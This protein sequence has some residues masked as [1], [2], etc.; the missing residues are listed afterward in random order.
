M[1]VEY[2]HIRRQI[3]VKI[4]RMVLGD[5]SDLESF[6]DQ[7]FI[8]DLKINLIIGLAENIRV[9]VY[10]YIEKEWDFINQ[11][12]R[13]ADDQMLENLSKIK[14][15]NDIIENGNS[16]EE[17]NNN[18][19]IEGE[20]VQIIDGE[21]SSANKT[22]II[23]GKTIT[24]LHPRG[25]PANG[26]QRY[27]HLFAAGVIDTGG[28][29]NP[30]H[31]VDV[32]ELPVSI[33]NKFNVF[34][35]KGYSLNAG[36]DLLN[37]QCMNHQFSI[38][39]L[40][41]YKAAT[42]GVNIPFEVFYSSVDKRYWPDP[43]DS[44]TI[45]E[46][47]ENIKR[48]VFT[49]YKDIYQAKNPRGADSALVA[50][51]VGELGY[52]RETRMIYIRA[53]D[54]FRRLYQVSSLTF[55]VNRNTITI[56]ENSMAKVFMIWLSSLK[57]KIISEGGW[58]NFS[59]NEYSVKRL[60][61]ILSPKRSGIYNG[62]D[63]N[64][65]ARALLY[66]ETNGLV[67]YSYEFLNKRTTDVNDKCLTLATKIK[68]ISHRLANKK[69][70]FDGEYLPSINIR[71][72]KNT[73]EK[74]SNIALMINSIQFLKG[75]NASDS[76]SHAEWFENNRKLLD[77]I[78][79]MIEEVYDKKGP[80]EAR[81]YLGELHKIKLNTLLRNLNQGNHPFSPKL[82]DIISQSLAKIKKNAIKP[83]TDLLMSI[84]IK[85]KPHKTNETHISWYDKNEKNIML[86]KKT[87]ESIIAKKGS[88]SGVNKRTYKA[89]LID[90]IYFYGDEELSLFFKNAYDNN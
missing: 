44:K 12:I 37:M 31:G 53:V 90:P 18:D 51:I 28:G 22:E 13:V 33:E 43:E 47:F 2:G 11:H 80:V 66:L 3:A 56:A 41:E 75:A 76:F 68:F 84:I 8:P 48:L 40:S 89:R 7:V 9:D 16:L 67:R 85:I 45:I 42:N 30:L 52:D 55:E 70:V 29:R 5:R 65:L 27:L 26:I 17:L 61:Q 83:D 78:C 39:S 72:T 21:L 58:K 23:P 19:I 4:L 88:V 14:H 10:T 57:A 36:I 20:F 64:K 50:N 6:I 24:A 63:I 79:S 86:A 32:Y 59:D 69:S 73:K 71:S 77:N 15:Y 74:N 38:M 25:A 60:L 87:I 82:D 62:S 49:L 54:I 81:I 1:E 46:S 34:T 35:I